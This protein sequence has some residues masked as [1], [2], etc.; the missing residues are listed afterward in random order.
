MELISKM[1]LPF[2]QASFCVSLSVMWRDDMT[3]H[4][5]LHL[6]IDNLD[7]ER[8]HSE[9]YEE[10]SGKCMYSLIYYLSCFFHFVKK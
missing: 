6:Y 7:D 1:P 10:R 8:R 2:I 5:V 4:V 9:K 3:S